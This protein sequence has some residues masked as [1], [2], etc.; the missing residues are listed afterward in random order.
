MEHKFPL[1]SFRRENGTTFSEVPLFPEI[2][3]WD[4]PKVVFHLHPNRNFRNFLVNGKRPNK[5]SCRSPD[6]LFRALCQWR[7]EKRASDEWGLVG[8][9][10]RSFLSRIPLAADPA[11]RPLAFSIILTDREP[12]T[13]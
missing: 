10:E 5:K 1:G 2:F 7:T 9:K 3:Q 13:G 6:R 11:L 12:G 8:K 4:K